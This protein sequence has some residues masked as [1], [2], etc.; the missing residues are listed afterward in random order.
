[1]VRLT[2]F[3]SQ[4][5]FYRGSKKRTFKEERRYSDWSIPHE[6]AFT[7]DKL[8]RGFQLFSTLLL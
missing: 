7:P 4:V 1:M 5:A 8:Q 2:L 6:R 3:N